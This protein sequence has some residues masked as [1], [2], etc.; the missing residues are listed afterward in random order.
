MGPRNLKKNLYLWGDPFR[1]RGGSEGLGRADCDRMSAEKEFMST[2]NKAARKARKRKSRL[3]SRMLWGAAGT[4]AALGVLVYVLVFRPGKRQGGPSG[5]AAYNILLITLDTTRADHLGCYGYEKAGTPHLDGLARGGVR[6]ARAYCPAPLTLPAHCTIMTGVEPAAH[7]V[8]NNGHHLA[9]ATRTLAEGLKEAG[10]A[11]SAFVS[12]FSV[13]SRFGLDRG[14]DV[15]DDTFS[16]DMPYKTLNAERRAEQTLVRF[17]RW[18]D[19]NGGRRFFS[20]VHFYDPH[21]PY[22]PPS[23][24]KERFPGRPYDGEIAYMDD[25]VGA[26][27]DGL[28]ERGL[29][30][31]TIVVVAG[32]HGEGLG[33]KVE[34][35]HGIFLYEETLRV[36]LIMNNPAAFPRPRVV[37]SQV[38]LVDLAPTILDVLGFG[39]RAAAMKGRSLV[40]RIEGKGGEDLDALV[41]TVY[42]R[43]NFG[44]SEL[45]G[46]VSGGWKYVQS[47]RPEIVRSGSGPGRAPEP[48]RDVGRKGRRD[49][50]AA[51][52]GAPEGLGRRPVGGR[53]EVGPRAEDVERLKSLGYVNFAPS[54][55]GDVPRGPQG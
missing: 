45:V 15:Y 1:T 5:P 9:P 23:P 51:G 16:P 44:W 22:D 53:G 7:G 13:D 35:G 54:R 21:W 27:L 47:P 40:S 39:D 6:F 8:R 10:Y 36:P 49:E 43:E 55:P 42:P 17:S 50:E 28:R 20:W 48:V 19:K 2:N 24:F 29:L 11:T 26:L 12:S 4:A 32:D 33:E 46:L 31:R 14:F 37:E 41:E 18:L 3:R 25:Q 38:R 30:E 52:A 34:M